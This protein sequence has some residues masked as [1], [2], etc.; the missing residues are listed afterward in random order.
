[1]FPFQVPN[2]TFWL[3]PDTHFLGSVYHHVTYLI[4][5]VMTYFLFRKKLSNVWIYTV[6]QTLPEVLSMFIATRLNET[7]DNNQLIS[8]DSAVPVLC[9]CTK[10]QQMST[11]VWLHQM[12]T[13]ATSIRYFDRPNVASSM[14]LPH[15]RQISG[16]KLQTII[17]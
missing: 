7:F 4:F 9:Y 3:L 14:D 10:Y 13:I 11:A 1:M 5:I 16:L 15:A 2:V 12:S 6:G 17:V 8:F